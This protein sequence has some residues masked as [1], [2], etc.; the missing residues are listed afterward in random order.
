MEWS[1]GK[2]GERTWM[3]FYCLPRLSHAACE[4]LKRWR[5]LLC[6]CSCASCRNFSGTLRLVLP[7]GI[8]L[9]TAA[10]YPLLQSLL[11][12][13]GCS[14]DFCLSRSHA[15]SRG[16]LSISPTH[17]RHHADPMPHGLR[18]QMMECHKGDAETRT[19]WNMFSGKL[20][21]LDIVSINSSILLCR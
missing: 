15:T 10:V 5:D 21:F 9:L 6:M 11:K 17:D 19:C 4:D 8:G 1:A 2:R 12:C 14:G 7:Q 16:L 18:T 3:D 20:G 13:S